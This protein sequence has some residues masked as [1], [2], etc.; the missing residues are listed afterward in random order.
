MPLTAAHMLVKVGFT[1]TA[2]PDREACSAAIARRI[3]V[4]YMRLLPFPS[5]CR[6][7]AT[8][9][10]LLIDAAALPRFRPFLLTQTIAGPF[11]TFPPGALTRGGGARSHGLMVP[12]PSACNWRSRFRS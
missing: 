8:I 7:S 5:D 11:A 12:S 3:S 4:Y 1:G 9:T 6:P 10:H 2:T